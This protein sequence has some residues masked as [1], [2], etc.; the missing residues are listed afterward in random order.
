MFAFYVNLVYSIVS[1]C[2]RGCLTIR[3]TPATSTSSTVGT[4]FTAN[5]ICMLSRQFSNLLFTRSRV[6]KDSRRLLGFCQRVQ[7]R[8]NRSWCQLQSGP[9]FHVEIWI[10]G[11]CVMR[12]GIFSS[13]VISVLIVPTVVTESIIFTTTTTSTT[14]VMTAIAIVVATSSTTTIAITMVAIPIVTT[15]TIPLVP[16]VAVSP[17]IWFSITIGSFSRGSVIRMVRTAAVESAAAGTTTTAS[18][19]STVLLTTTL[20]TTTIIFL[21]L[22][23][24][25]S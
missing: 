20:E 23:D 24:V 3:A 6:S 22:R 25:N 14:T 9:F 16:K 2:Y 18:W 17:S 11:W 8:I 19:S 13:I 10:R 7:R 15:T 21:L 1:T 12:G 4:T 5:T